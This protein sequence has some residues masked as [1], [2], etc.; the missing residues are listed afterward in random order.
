MKRA[1]VWNARN[2]QDLLNAL[3]VGLLVFLVSLIV[4]TLHGQEPTGWRVPQSV[5]GI[6]VEKLVNEKNWTTEV[7]ERMGYWTWTPEGFHHQAV[8]QVMHAGGA[9]TGTLIW[10]QSD[11]G[12]GIV[13]TAAHVHAEGTG[14]VKWQNG[15]QINSQALVADHRADVSLL[16]VAETPRGAPVIPVSRVDP[17]P[18]EYVEQCGF[19]GPGDNLR[20]FYGIVRN[21][22]GADLNTYAYL[23]NGDSG[24]PVLYQGAI[25]SVHS[26]GSEMINVGIGLAE[27]G[28]DWPLHR[29]SRNSHPQALRNLLSA[30]GAVS[31]TSNT[32][33]CFPGG[34][35]PPSGGQRG[36]INIGGGGNQY[37]P[38][39][40][41]R[42]I[43]SIGG[44]NNQYGAPG[45]QQ[46][47]PQ[48]GFDPYVPP[49]PQG[50]NNAQPTPAPATPDGNQG[51]PCQGSCPCHPASP[52]PG[53]VAGCNCDLDAIRDKLAQM[54]EELEAQIA[55][56]EVS[57]SDSQISA[58]AAKVQ[59]SQ[60]QLDLVVQQ[61]V[62]EMPPAKLDPAEINSIVNTIVGRIPAG[63]AGPP[64][65]QG[66]P[67]PAGDVDTD[68]LANLVN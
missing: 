49:A 45:Q 37:Y 32:Q 9:G 36:I 4:T 40:G 34:F 14:R 58:I 6:P 30:V 51:C 62:Q 54:R 43:I 29:P 21:Y 50:G 19:G 18:G 38:G 20:H 48:G 27:S 7:Q 1:G 41:Q 15:S 17:Q 52:Q 55:A 10:K 42:G 47:T 23:L 60:S 63:P 46:G 26:G 3:L 66:P 39:G 11:G 64:G 22:D 35:C 68:A 28:Q 16:W 2:T 53:D 65:P 31:H 59:L 57:L 56:R 24:G 33:Q 13:A 67:G 25:I 12:P 61:V 8:L 44:R 5:N